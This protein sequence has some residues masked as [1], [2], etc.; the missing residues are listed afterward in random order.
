MAEMYSSPA[1]TEPAPDD[2]DDM[3]MQVDN[4]TGDTPTALLP[5]AFFEGKELE[6]GSTCTVKISRVLDDQV[7]VTY[8]PHTEPEVG[9]EAVS[10]PADAEM[11]GYMEE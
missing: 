2:A 11:A 1:P 8:V 5:I 9:E 4:P 10:T 7:E 3:G 6:P